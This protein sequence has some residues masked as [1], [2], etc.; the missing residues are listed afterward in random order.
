M[1][2]AHGAAPEPGETAV[3]SPLPAAVRLSFLA[4][5]M[6]SMIDSSVV[7]VA[8]PGIVGGLHASLGTAAWAVSGYLLGL[9]CGLAAT[10]WLARRYGTLPAYGAALL[11]FTLASAACALVP[12]VALLIAARVVQGLAGAP[13]VPLAMSLILDPAR[14]GD[15][16][17]GMPASAGV[18]LFAAPALGPAVGGLLISAFGW[19]SVFLVNLPIGL[20]ALAGVRAARRA[21]AVGEPGA[22]QVTGDR[23][24]RLDI[25]GLLLLA[26]GL[27]LATYGASKGPSL[28]WLSPGPALA[29]GGGLAL[30]ACY[31]LR[32]QLARKHGR[33]A[34]AP[35]NLSLLRSPARA[36]TL[37]LACIA[38]VVLF[39]VLF[40]APVFLQQIQHHST[41][42]TGLVLL[43]QGIVMGLASW[44][45]S[46]VIERGKARPAVITVSVAGG[47]TLLAASTL[48][49]LLL[50]QAT[51]LWVTTA[52]LCGRG[53]AL[54]LTIQPLVMVL[55]GGSP[56]SPGSPALPA[57]AMP[58]ANTLF[59][60]AERL[61][62]SF[63]IA[64]LA[65][66]YASRAAATGDPVAALH[67]CALVLTVAAAVG[68]VAAA[69]NHGVSASD[70]GFAQGG[71][72][73]R[74]HHSAAASQ[75]ADQA[76]LTRQ[77]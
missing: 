6:L 17:R 35:V 74:R 48:G 30:V 38:S 21:L 40:L 32:E 33:R 2:P 24:A 25:T 5:P 4:G 11:A 29:W 44:L 73:G 51:P 43:P 45:G 69:C 56:G 62:G 28:G 46:V 61:S 20:L 60:M 10:P 27:G 19:R 12:S 70:A 9:A 8:V 34:P 67:D 14:A 50:G 64:L 23:G 16:A 26:A 54:G 47:L 36:F 7:N 55:L 68:A 65:T 3:A 42:V 41:T 63:G 66:V 52:L 13:M 31:A 76:V 75:R 77:P 59:N 39:A 71:R 22:G 49:L 57:S 58:D 53:V 1:T 72:H 15:R 37:A 18:V